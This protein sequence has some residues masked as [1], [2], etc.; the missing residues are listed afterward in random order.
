MDFIDTTM[1][2]TE[3]VIR[4]PWHSPSDEKGDVGTRKPDISALLNV[5]ESNFYHAVH[6]LLKSTLST[7]TR[8]AQSEKARDSQPE[9]IASQVLSFQCSHL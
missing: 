7:W 5:M 3:Q 8:R 2:A 9:G 1:A 4:I 6:V